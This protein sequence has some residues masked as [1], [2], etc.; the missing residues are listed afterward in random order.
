M[1]NKFPIAEIFDSI[2]GEGKRTGLMAVFVRFAGCSL[3]CS[4]CD[5]GYALKKED[6]AAWLTEQDIL[7]K[8]HAYPWK[9]ITV[10]GGEPLL[11]PIQ[12][13][14]EVLGQEGYEVNVETSGAEPLLSHRPDHLF[15]TM[16]YKCPGSGMEGAMRLENIPLLGK[17]DV[18]KF[19][20]AGPGDLQRMADVL[21]TL[22]AHCPA[23]VYVSPVWG[24]IA[25]A[26]IVEF[27]REKQLARVRVQVQL[28]KIIWDPMERGV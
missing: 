14:C 3:R 12:H 26:D 28:H 6:A 5:T 20:V 1:K 19:V 22:F 24:K 4:Y 25:P 15:Y 27:I 17:Q 9:K 13:L 10:T 23:A 11:Q 8:I 2:D 21:Q 7:E 18:V 16:D